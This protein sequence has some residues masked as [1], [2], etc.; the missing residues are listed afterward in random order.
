MYDVIVIV[1]Y[2][3]SLVIFN[4]RYHMIIKNS[5]VE[6]DSPKHTFAIEKVDKIASE[7]V[8]LIVQFCLTVY[9]LYDTDVA[10]SYY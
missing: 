6:N 4:T 2:C 10:A 1:R 5:S 8:G 9:K 7:K 3:H